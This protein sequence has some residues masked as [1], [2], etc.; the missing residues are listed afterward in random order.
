M[1]ADHSTR[2]ARDYSCPTDARRQREQ[3]PLHYY[4][5]RI[6]RVKIRDNIDGKS[7]GQTVTRYIGGRH[8]TESVNSR[9]EMLVTFSV[10][11]P[12]ESVPQ[13][14]HAIRVIS[15]ALHCFRA[16]ESSEDCHSDTVEVLIGTG[17]EPPVTWSD[18]KPA[19][20]YVW[21][22][23]CAASR[24]TLR[25]ARRRLQSLVI[26]ASQCTL[27]F[28]PQGTKSLTRPPLES[29]HCDWSGYYATALVHI[30]V[31]LDPNGSLFTLQ[32]HIV[33]GRLLSTSR[34]PDLVL[35]STL[36]TCAPDPLF[37]TTDTPLLHL[38]WALEE[39]TWALSLLQLVTQV[40][41]VRWIAVV[42][43]VLS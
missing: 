8:P 25:I 3:T 18:E 31:P 5:S 2:G 19:C 42:F 7:A 9:P 33:R 23:H 28:C 11:H 1:K 10:S 24:P 21:L 27:V 20:G 35:C 12:P 38:R 22:D 34:L 36:R 26:Q 29:M 37:P 13:L 15:A 6:G 17:I 32:V 41:P 14:R 43:Q 16:G 39:Q 30:V 4:H 40:A